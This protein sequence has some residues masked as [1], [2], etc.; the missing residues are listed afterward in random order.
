[1]S[2][3]AYIPT[4][5]IVVRPLPSLSSLYPSKLLTQS[6][7]KGQLLVSCS[8]LYPSKFCNFKTQI[9][10]CLSSCHVLK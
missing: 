5:L 1:M 3:K 2:I 6:R 7:L 4:G 10:A 8:S 9:S